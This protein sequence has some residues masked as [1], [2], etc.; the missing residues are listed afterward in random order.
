[1]NL[2][3]LQSIL[4]VADAYIGALLFVIS[5]NIQVSEY[6]DMIPVS[7]RNKLEKS[8]RLVNI[9]DREEN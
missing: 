6:F 8:I 4:M 3:S 9:H 1:M 2:A 5:K 7:H